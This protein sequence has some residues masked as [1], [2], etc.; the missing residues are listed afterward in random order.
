MEYIVKDM[1]FILFYYVIQWLFCK[2]MVFVV[3]KD[4]IILILGKN[5]N[6]YL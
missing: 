1:I 5:V 2:N 4:L 6:R 3:L